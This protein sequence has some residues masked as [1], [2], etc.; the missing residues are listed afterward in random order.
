MKRLLSNITAAAMLMCSI[1]SAGIPAA[2]KE[3]RTD[4][5]DRVKFVDTA[6]S[7]Y[8]PD[9]LTQSAF[10]MDGL[11]TESHQSTAES[12]EELDRILSE[13]LLEAPRKEFE[14]QYPEE[15]FYDY[16]LMLCTY[17]DPTR[18]RLVGGHK[19]QSAELETQSD[20]ET[21][22]Y[23]DYTS[24]FGASICKTHCF[25]ILQVIVPNRIYPTLGWE[26]HCTE[27]LEPGLVR[28]RAE[29]A[30]TGE[31]LNVPGDIDKLTILPTIAY[32]LE[33]VDNYAYADMASLEF[34]YDMFWD[35][36]QYMDADILD[37]SLS[38]ASLPEGWTLPENY[39]SVT[40]YENGSM[41]VVFRLRRD[42]PEKGMLRVWLKDADTG[43]LIVSRNQNGGFGSI[44]TNI[45]F[46]DP[47]YG[48]VST[49][50]ILMI[51][52]NPC[53]QQFD[54]MFS[55]DSYE[56]RLSEWD[57]PRG[58]SSNAVFSNGVSIPEGAI[59]AT[60]Y[61]NGSA[62]IVFR[63]K[64]TPTGD[65]SGDGQ[66]TVSDAVSV[67]KWLLGEDAELADWKAADYNNDNR[68]NAADL[69]L[70]LRAALSVTP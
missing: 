29:D 7:V 18:G 23:L 49:G 28:F 56:Y 19:L 40:R 32:Y 11:F 67:Q 47:Q 45:S 53:V 66:S 10:E 34:S 50:P 24:T 41:D 14:A 9:T 17:M 25:E 52:T 8:A 48:T 65:V 33:D 63:L 16:T 27:S 60:R 30:D 68:L 3:T 64:F 1:T 22:L 13:Y 69:T 54:L 21:V 37:F 44:G 57:L 15:F 26:W 55:G 12:P 51:D 6:Y 38:Q 59:E 5:L 46:N 31:T 35:A 61:E 43:A 58:Y 39:R 20:G 70:M 42:I 36:S 2:A 62:D 4:I